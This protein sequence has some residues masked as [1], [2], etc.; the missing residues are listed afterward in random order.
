MIESEMCTH[1]MNLAL[2]NSE[3][4]RSLSDNS[5]MHNFSF[6]FINR[7]NLSTLIISWW[8]QP[9]VKIFLVFCK[10]TFNIVSYYQKHHRYKWQYLE[11]VS[12]LITTFLHLCRLQRNADHGH[13]TYLSRIHHINA[14]ISFF[15]KEPVLYGR[16]IRGVVCVAT[17]RLHHSQGNLTIWGPHDFSAFILFKVA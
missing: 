17:V 1:R 7:L 11:E 4:L 9:L 16:Q 10:I 6:T 12:G 2:L 3:I 15:L 14:P 8:I 5:S 13:C